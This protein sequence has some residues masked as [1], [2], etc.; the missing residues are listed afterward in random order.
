MLILY[1]DE[2]V[3]AFLHESN[4]R[5][6]SDKYVMFENLKIS[7]LNAND[8]NG[9]ILTRTRILQSVDKFGDQKGTSFSFVD[10]ATI[11][12]Q[13]P[14]TFLSLSSTVCISSFQNV[15]GLYGNFRVTLEGTIVELGDLDFALQGDNKRTFKLVDPVGYYIMCTAIKH[16][17]Y[18]KASREQE[19]VIIYFGTGRGPIAS[20]C[21]CVYIMKDGLIVSRG[22]NNGANIVAQHEIVITDNAMATLAL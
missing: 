18:S 2:L 7:A 8:W 22:N 15:K 1:G 17:A 5:R 6:A 3:T 20:T 11:H 9:N 21:G 16:N 19:S 4:V 13:T 10:K 12:N 14:S